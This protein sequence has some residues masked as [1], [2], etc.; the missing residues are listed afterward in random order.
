VNRDPIT[1]IKEKKERQAELLTLIF[2][3]F[4]KIK[5]EKL[6]VGVSYGGRY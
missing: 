4:L 3:D 1:N 5:L 6:N 2:T